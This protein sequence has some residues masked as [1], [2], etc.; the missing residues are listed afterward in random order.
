MEFRSRCCLHERSSWS[1]LAVATATCVPYNMENSGSSR[2]LSCWVEVSF[3]AGN[4]FASGLAL[5]CG[6]LVGMKQ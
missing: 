3:E 5:L 2:S 4:M 6:I 1:L